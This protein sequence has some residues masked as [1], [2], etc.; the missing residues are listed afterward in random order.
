MA[1]AEDGR[2]TK[3]MTAPFVKNIRLEVPYYGTVT[4]EPNDFYFS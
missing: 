1:I 2:T 4:I 3:M